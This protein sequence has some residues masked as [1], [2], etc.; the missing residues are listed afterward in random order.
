MSAWITIDLDDWDKQCPLCDRWGRLGYCVPYYE[1]PCPE[2]EIGDRL[3]NGDEVGGMTC[4]QTCH[5]SVYAKAR[6]ETP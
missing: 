1:E 6:G 5:D 4:C 2:R 3:P